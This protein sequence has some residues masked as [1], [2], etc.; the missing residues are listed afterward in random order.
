[1]PLCIIRRQMSRTLCG[2]K[3]TKAACGMCLAWFP[4][5]TLTIQVTFKAILRFR[6]SIADSDDEAVHRQKEV[7]Y[8]FPTR[9][10]DAKRVC[11]LCAD[12]LSGMPQP[13]DELDRLV[14]V[15]SP[16]RSTAYWA[17]EMDVIAASLEDRVP[18]PPFSSRRRRR[19]HNVTAA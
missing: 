7:L 2:M 14:T 13:V 8:R 3:E 1:V 10:Y 12:I 11:V 18:F 15:K 5:S 16:P 19:L 9:A 4:K 6:E 17:A